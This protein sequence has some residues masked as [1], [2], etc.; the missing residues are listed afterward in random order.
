MAPKIQIAHL[1]KILKSAFRSLKIKI[2]TKIVDVD[3][4]DIYKCAKNQSQIH[5]IFGSEKMTNM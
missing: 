1:L 3:N 5:G 2:K 4:S